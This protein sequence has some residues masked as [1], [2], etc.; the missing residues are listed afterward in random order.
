MESMRSSR[1]TLRDALSEHPPPVW[2]R[3]ERGHADD[4]CP[5]GS[6]LSGGDVVHDP[7][8]ELLVES[9]PEQVDAGPGLSGL[10][11]VMVRG[12]CPI[13]SQQLV[14]AFIDEDGFAGQYDFLY[15]PVREKGSQNT[16]QAFV[17]FVSPEHAQAFFDRYNGQNAKFASDEKRLSVLPAK[18][19]GYE[20]NLNHFREKPST[21]N[22]FFA[23]AS[24]LKMP[25]S[26]EP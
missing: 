9:C 15:V 11:A 1:S 5:A 23:H 20:A 19:Q 12:V 6:S 14:K 24:D 10:T 8:A 18:R 3:H 13:L 7:Q 26:T 22:P 2:P 4:R 16:A 17:N 25:T 21:T